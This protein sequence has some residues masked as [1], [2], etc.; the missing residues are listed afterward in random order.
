MEPRTWIFLLPVWALLW[1]RGVDRISRKKVLGSPPGVAAICF[2]VL[3]PSLKV[4]VDRPPVYRLFPVRELVQELEKR[5][6]P[7][8]PVYAFWYSGAVVGYYGRRFGLD[9]GVEVATVEDLRGNLN[10]LARYKGRP[11]VWVLFPHPYGAERQVV[12]CFLRTVGQ[13]LEMLELGAPGQDGVLS[14]HRFDLGDRSRWEGVDPDRYPIDPD[15]LLRTHPSCLDSPRRPSAE[16]G[17][18]S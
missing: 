12:L 7:G 15:A 5:R 9:G 4:V 16:E 8:D 13:E 17:Q 1:G 3:L 10:D 11:V 18:G 14:L 6:S 2:L